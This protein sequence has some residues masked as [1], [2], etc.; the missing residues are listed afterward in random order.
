MYTVTV[1]A[2]VN[3]ALVKYWGKRD[4][5]LNLPIHPSISMTLSSL[6]LGTSTKLTVFPS[7]EFS[8]EFTLNGVQTEAPSRVS[9]VLHAAHEL[10]LTF[11]SESDWRR[12]TLAYSIQTTNDGPTGSGLASSASGYAALAFALIQF[13]D[14]TAHKSL[15][16]LSFL[17]RLG[18]GS[19]C[20]SFFPGFVEWKQTASPVP[21][22]D[23]A[24][25]RFCPF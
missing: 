17:A 24:G 12:G 15:S 3:I 19:A 4:E 11:L 23:P 9:L 20:R 6:Y 21:S 16:S 1:R 2:P 18:S 13:Y 10:A 14:L 5:S 22:L 7:S 8:I 25:Q